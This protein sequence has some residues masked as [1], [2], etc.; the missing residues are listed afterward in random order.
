MGYCFLR[1]R[2]RRTTPQLVSTGHRGQETLRLR[3]G[4][5]Q[6][7]QHHPMSPSHVR[8][9]PGHGHSPL[10]P[11][12]WM[13]QYW[14]AGSRSFPGAGTRL[15]HLNIINVMSPLLCILTHR[16]KLCGGR[17]GG[18]RPQGA[19]LARPSPGGRGRGEAGLR[20]RGC[21]RGQS[22]SPRDDH[23]LWTDRDNPASRKYSVKISQPH[24]MCRKDQSFMK[25]FFV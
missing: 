1:P 24:V 9:S 10:W 13:D 2:A 21:A 25:P 23:H 16:P 6:W 11:L 22:P 15:G 19:G 5:L 3:L 17:G 12:C 4:P 14:L 7:S 8:A 18:A 20:P